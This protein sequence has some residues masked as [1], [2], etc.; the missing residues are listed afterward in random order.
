[1]V[2][3]RMT[4]RA[5]LFVRGK[6]SSL[7]RDLACK[8]VE[9]TLVFSSYSE[10][11]GG[12]R[13]RKP[14]RAPV[15]RDPIYIASRSEVTRICRKES[16]YQASNILSDKPVTMKMRK[17]KAMT[18]ARRSQK[19]IKKLSEHLGNSGNSAQL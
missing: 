6:V 4:Q 7:E 3:R 14:L 10:T 8:K 13:T 19:I 1:M 16:G 5:N 18:S 17:T 11:D 12:Q 9:A 2:E 15:Y